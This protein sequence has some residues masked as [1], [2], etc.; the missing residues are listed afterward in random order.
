M[1]AAHRAGGRTSAIALRAGVGPLRLRSRGPVAT[2][3]G[4]RAR[5]AG[6]QVYLQ[7]SL[8]ASPVPPDEVKAGQGRIDQPT[9]PA[10]P[11]PA[12]DPPRNGWAWPG[13]ERAYDGYDRALARLEPALS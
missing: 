9:A 12:E 5:V 10:R 6:A 13:L 11:S 8:L 3:P 1:L 2:A 4:H 7:A